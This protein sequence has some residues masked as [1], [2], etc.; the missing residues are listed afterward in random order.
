MGNDSKIVMSGKISS[1]KGV[2]LS[3]SQ[4]S[5]INP[6]EFESIIPEFSNTN[7]LLKIFGS[8][9]GKL[10]KPKAKISFQTEDFLFNTVKL[11]SMEG[12]L[13][14]SHENRELKL[15]PINAKLG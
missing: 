13:N 6:K 8:I 5:I 12:Q 11:D 2:L 4:N 7:G 1:Q 9:E 15:L 10:T 3:I 14:Y